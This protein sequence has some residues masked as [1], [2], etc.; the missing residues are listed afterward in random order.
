L[1]NFKGKFSETR[2]TIEIGMFVALKWAENSGCHGPSPRAPLLIFKRKKSA[3][4]SESKC[5]KFPPFAVFSYQRKAEQEQCPPTLFS[6]QR[7]AMRVLAATIFERPRWQ[8]W[9]A[10]KE[11]FHIQ[12]ANFITFLCYFFFQGKLSCM[13]SLVNPLT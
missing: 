1:P 13:T 12:V 4:Q 9:S 2:N 11:V 5:Y 6:Y 3:K 8:Q 10:N 7:K